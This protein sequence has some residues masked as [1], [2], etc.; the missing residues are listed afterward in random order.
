MRS[1]SSVMMPRHSSPA[2]SLGGSQLIG[3]PPSGCCWGFPC[4]VGLVGVASLG[5]YPR[6]RAGAASDP[7][8]SLEPEHSFQHLRPVAHCRAT[9]GV[10]PAFSY[11]QGPAGDLDGTKSLRMS[12]HEHR[13]EI[14][15]QRV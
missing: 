4:E 15:D 9:V 5:R 7:P 11:A 6:E 3:Q 8:G 13:Q 14:V 12:G 10:Q 2:A 1:A